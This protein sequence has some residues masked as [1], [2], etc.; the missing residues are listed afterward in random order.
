[1]YA[2]DR[3]I[4]IYIWDAG[5]RNE[6]IRSTWSAVC[7]SVV[8]CVAVCCSVLYTYGMQA[9]GTKQ[10]EL[11]AVQCVAV[12]CSVLQCVAVCC[13]VLQCVAVCYI[14][15]GCRHEERS[16]TKY[17]EKLLG[18]SRGSNHDDRQIYIYICMH[19]YTE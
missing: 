9:R 1:M 18:S 7:C 14:H 11:H 15:M 5:T 12:C 16:N 6:A 2:N 8:Q 4:D 10:Y 19:I 13:S 3:Q 17:M